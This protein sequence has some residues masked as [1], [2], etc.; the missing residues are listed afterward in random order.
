MKKRGRRGDEG[1][2]GEPYN[3]TG[4]LCERSCTSSL[5]SVWTMPER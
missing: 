3:I 2:K 5:T 4:S 1:K